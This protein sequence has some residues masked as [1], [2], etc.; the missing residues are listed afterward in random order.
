MAGGRAAGEVGGAA[1][2]QL[3]RHV[4]MS[5]RDVLSCWVETLGH[6]LASVGVMLQFVTL[7]G[8]S[9]DW[10]LYQAASADG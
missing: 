8:D 2:A 7:G 9:D 1:V 4:P 10:A 5:A 3:K 6:N